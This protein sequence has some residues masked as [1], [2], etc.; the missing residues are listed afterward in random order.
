MLRACCFLVGHARYAQA[1]LKNRAQRSAERRLLVAMTAFPGKEAMIF[2]WLPAV[3]PVCKVP[4]ELK[5]ILY[6]SSDNQERAV[7]FFFLFS[8]FPLRILFPPCIRSKRGQS[9]ICPR[10]GR[11]Y[12]PWESCRPKRFLSDGAGQCPLRQQASKP[13]DPASQCRAITSHKSIGECHPAHHPFF[14]CRF[15]STIGPAKDFYFL[16]SGPF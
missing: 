3:F 14:I 11:R 7:P 8:S 6:S 13:P 16:P 2:D 10:Y 4:G 15:G 9:S 5:R 12:G 1:F